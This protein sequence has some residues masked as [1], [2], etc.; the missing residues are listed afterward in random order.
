MN[1]SDL[2]D[3]VANTLKENATRLSPKNLAAEVVDALGAAIGNALV[4]GQD[5]TLIDL[6]KLKI[7]T[8]AAKPER[9]GTNPKTKEPMV[10]AAQGERKVVKFRPA[11]ALKDAVSGRSA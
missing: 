3:V 2:R 4:N 10:L 1:K 5:V 6:G 11:L 9:T 7:K 8:Q